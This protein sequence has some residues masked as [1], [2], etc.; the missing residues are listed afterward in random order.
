MRPPSHF[1]LALSAAT[2]LL[3]SACGSREAKPPA[4]DFPPPKPEV[5]GREQSLGLRLELI[6][7]SVRT[8]DQG[9]VCWDLRTVLSNVTPDT[10]WIVDL[11]PLLAT[12]WSGVVQPFPY[13]PPPSPHNAVWIDGGEAGG[14]YLVR[15]KDLSPLGEEFYMGVAGN[16]S[17]LAESFGEIC[18]KP[19]QNGNR[20]YS[21]TTRR[22]LAP[23]EKI[24]YAYTYV[25]DGKAVKLDLT[26]VC[27]P[28]RMFRDEVVW[29]AAQ[30]SIKRDPKY[31]ERFEGVKMPPEPPHGPPGK[32]CAAWVGMLYIQ[33]EEPALPGAAPPAKP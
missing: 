10:W 1:A 23:G 21:T 3:A 20:V 6:R 2:A 9:R 22:A 19:V 14:G 26:Y 16:W 32:P 33:Y 7:D 29:K 4:P 25:R 18:I 27:P 28:N 11:T 13:P 17:C 12:P 15:E 5:L 30:E 8:D 24:E 31:F